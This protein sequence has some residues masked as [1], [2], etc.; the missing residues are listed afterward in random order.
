MYHQMA[1][2]TD[3]PYACVLKLVNFGPQIWPQ[4]WPTQSTHVR[5]VTFHTS[6]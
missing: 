4:F 2:Q 6:L 1:L 3:L 5:W